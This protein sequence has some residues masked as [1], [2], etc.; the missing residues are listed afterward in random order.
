MHSLTSVAA[1]LAG[2]GLLSSPLY[3]QT[4]VLEPVVV[5]ATRVE[6][7]VSDTLSDVSVIDREQIEAAGQST[8]TELLARQPG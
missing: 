1:L 3:A 6:Q 8:L 7:R 4:H 2:A 5:T